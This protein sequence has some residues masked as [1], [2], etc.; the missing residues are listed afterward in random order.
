MSNSKINSN[1]TVA[2]LVIILLHSLMNT[3]VFG[4]PLLGSPEEE[5]PNFQST[6]RDQ[7]HLM[8]G[9]DIFY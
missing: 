8:E 7:T 2:V 3:A 9:Y 5:S 4:K 1:Y 6:D